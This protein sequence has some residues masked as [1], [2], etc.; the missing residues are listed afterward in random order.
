M[1]ASEVTCQADV[2]YLDP[3]EKVALASA[4]ASA[5]QLLMLQLHLQELSQHL[6]RDTPREVI[7]ADAALTRARVPEFGRDGHMR[8]LPQRIDELADRRGTTSGS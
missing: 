8:T 2:K 6:L 7:E 5:L 4:P 1:R 3:M